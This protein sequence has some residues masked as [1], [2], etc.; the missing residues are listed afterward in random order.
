MSI[1]CLSVLGRPILAFI[2]LLKIGKYCENIGGLNCEYSAFQV[3]KLASSEPLTFGRKLSSLLPA[4]NLTL[5]MF[6]SLVE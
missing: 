6:C 1:L 3:V 2:N 4:E 5:F